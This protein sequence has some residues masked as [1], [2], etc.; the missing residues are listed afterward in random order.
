MHRYLHDVLKTSNMLSMIG[1]V[2]PAVVGALGCGDISQRS[3]VLATRFSSAQPD[4][5][6]LIPY[7]SGSV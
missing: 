7:N 4:Q 5:I 6:F 3:R 1:F 2:D